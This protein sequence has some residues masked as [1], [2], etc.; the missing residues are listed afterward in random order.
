MIDLDAMRLPEAQ[1]KRTATKTFLT[2]D[3]R[4]RVK[5]A[6]AFTGRPEYVIIEAAIVAALPSAK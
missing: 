2:D 6:A 1:T 4:A 5:A 3:A